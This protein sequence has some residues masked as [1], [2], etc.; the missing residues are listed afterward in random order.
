MGLPSTAD[1]PFFYRIL[2]ETGP[3]PTGGR[4]LCVFPFFLGNLTLKVT[5][6]VDSGYILAIGGKPPAREYPAYL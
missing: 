6:P 5:F 4:A 1:G 3:R 2:F